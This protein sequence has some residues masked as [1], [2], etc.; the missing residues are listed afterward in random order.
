E[1]DDADVD[2]NDIGQVSDVAQVNNIGHVSHIGEVNI[3]IDQMLATKRK[4][5]AKVN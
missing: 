2:V 3:I 5:Y 1:S 4:L